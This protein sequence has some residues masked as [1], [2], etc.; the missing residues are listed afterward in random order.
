MPPTLVL[1]TS[2]YA[3]KDASEGREAKRDGRPPSATAAN[4]NDVQIAAAA[5]AAA[6][7]SIRRRKSE[8]PLCPAARG[9]KTLFL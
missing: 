6:A 8:M 3:S 9:K 4:N 7:A 5:A 2:A 1:P